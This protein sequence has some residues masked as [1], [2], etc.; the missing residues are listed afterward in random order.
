MSWHA[1]KW[2][3]EDYRGDSSRDH[4]ILLGLALRADR[5]GITWISQDELARWA[6]CTRHTVMRALGSLEEEGLI[7]SEPIRYPDGKV[8][9]KVYRFAA[10]PMPRDWE[11]ERNALERSEAVQAAYDKLAQRALAVEQKVTRAVEQKVTQYVTESHTGRV[12][13]SH[14]IEDHLETRSETRSETIDLHTANG[15]TSSE[16]AI[17]R[18]DKRRGARFDPQ[19]FIDAWNEHS[20]ELPK[21]IKLT[22]KRLKALER[23]VA[24][25]ETPQHALELWTDAV[26]A[27]AR[28]EFWNERRYGFNNLLAGDK[29]IQRAEEWRSRSVTKAGQRPGRNG[30]KGDSPAVKAA[31][32]ASRLL[33]HI[34]STR[35]NG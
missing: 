22:G 29:V 13:E 14:S 20:G 12:T 9:G 2:V 8:G 23:L 25:H 17:V 3:D 33:A 26:R 6:R 18:G 15:E 30:Y 7:D 34:R 28:D 19:P 27:V 35:G 1:L 16:P 32:S 5:N 11:R 4:H 31:E 10:L 24:E 21:V